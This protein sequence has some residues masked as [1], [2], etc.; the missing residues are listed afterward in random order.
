[1][2]RR[3]LYFVLILT[4]AICNTLGAAQKGAAGM[5][6]SFNQT[7]Y[8]H[9]WSQNDQHEFTPSGQDDLSKWTDMLTINFYPEAND[10]EGLALIANQVLETY[11]TQNGKVLK[12]NS[13]P[14]TVKQPA[15]HLIVA[16][17]GRPEFLEAVEARFKMVNGRGV[18][19]IY[20]HRVYGKDA[21]PTMSDWLKAHGPATE[22][23]LMAWQFPQSLGSLQK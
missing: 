21:G 16:V 15:E 20:S 4:S 1:M 3:L 5:T 18:S 7:N 22:K 11:K 17:F 10:G 9:R 6:L 2:P 23:T 12:T 13:V 19:I 8:V 14:R